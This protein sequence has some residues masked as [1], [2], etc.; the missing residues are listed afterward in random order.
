VIKL[1]GRERE[2]ERRRLI[3]LVDS[4]YPELR[5]EFH[6]IIFPEEF[7]MPVASGWSLD[8][9]EMVEDWPGNTAPK[10]RG[11]S[12]VGGEVRLAGVSVSV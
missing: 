5:G 8:D 3:L 12:Q 2:A 10:F 7:N 11:E 4:H 1:K 9:Y 6:D